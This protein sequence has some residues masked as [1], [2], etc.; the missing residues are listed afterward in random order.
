MIN[1]PMVLHSSP[2]I[3]GIKINLIKDFPKISPLIK[4]M[5]AQIDN[6]I[7]VEVN[8][9]TGN[10]FIVYDERIPPDVYYEQI[11][12]GCLSELPVKPANT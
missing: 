9:L 10:V 8:E 1:N 6:T 11:I 5:V 7:D 12:T 3:L 2:G 4:N